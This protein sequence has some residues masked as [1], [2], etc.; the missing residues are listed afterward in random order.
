MSKKIEFTQEQWI[1]YSEDGEDDKKRIGATHVCTSDTRK[2]ASWRRTLGW[3]EWKKNG[4]IP[5]CEECGE[6]IPKN[7]MGLITLKNRNL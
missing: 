3:T 5:T 1:V 6:E 4:T 2:R 7:I